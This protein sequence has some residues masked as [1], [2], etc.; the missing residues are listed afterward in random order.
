MVTEVAVR[1]I[2]SLDLHLHNLRQGQK[3]VLKWPPHLPSDIQDQASNV[4]RHCDMRNSFDI[5]SKEEK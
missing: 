3:Y 5:I 2:R 4:R 1:T